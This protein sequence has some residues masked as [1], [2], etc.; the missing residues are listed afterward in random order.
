MST[1][2]MAGMLQGLDPQ[3]QALVQA[4]ASQRPRE[5]EVTV[6]TNQMPASIEA[7]NLQR[8]QEYTDDVRNDLT[9]LAPGLGRAAPIAGVLKAFAKARYDAGAEATQEEL[10]NRVRDSLAAEQAQAQAAA[11][12]EYERKKADERAKYERDQAAALEQWQRE[13]AAAQQQRQQERGYATSDADLAHQRDM[14]MEAY[15]ASLQPQK[16]P[17]QSLEDKERIKVDAKRAGALKD[18][19]SDR[20]STIQDAVKF[21]NHFEGGAESG[22]TR[23]ALKWVPGV[24]SSQQQ[25]DEEIDAFAERAARAQLKAMGETRATDADVEG[26]KR[27]MFGSGRDEV[28]NKQLLDKFITS[29]IETENELRRMEGGELLPVPEVKATELPPYWGGDRN[30]SESGFKIRQVR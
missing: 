16:A 20:M 23:S 7:N 9:G 19:R 26:M 29:Q 1:N 13:Q 15:R 14:E 10:S 24:W 22:A 30:E 17:E 12:A 3:T 18:S 4:I 8:H 25:F 2:L 6:K 5:R 28:T 21:R 11:Q 27:A